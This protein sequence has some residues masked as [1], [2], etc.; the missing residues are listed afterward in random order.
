MALLKLGELYRDKKY[1]ARSRSGGQDGQL[2]VHSQGWHRARRGRSLITTTA[3]A[4]RQ[5]QDRKTQCVPHLR[6][7]PRAELTS[8]P[9]PSP[10]PPRL[11]HRD[12]GQ[13]RA[14]D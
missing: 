10:H 11:L 2:T 14:A 1:A 7:R 9:P 13:Q 3:R 8:G 5:G 4:P 6:R 12:P